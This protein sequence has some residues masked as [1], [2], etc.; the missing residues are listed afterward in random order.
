MDSWWSALNSFLTGADRD[1][2]AFWSSASRYPPL[3]VRD[4]P[5]SRSTEA[6]LRRLRREPRDK[7]L[8]VG[9]FLHLR[10]PLAYE[11]GEKVLEYHADA[12]REYS[13]FVRERFGFEEKVDE[14]CDEYD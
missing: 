14:A 4:I 9:R 8:R 7:P 2:R 3:S 1:D 11:G 13:D 10:F 12:V 6:N 5:G